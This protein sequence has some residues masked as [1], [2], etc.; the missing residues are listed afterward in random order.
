[1]F[2]PED[3]TLVLLFWYGLSVGYSILIGSQ[4]WC[5]SF[6][7]CRIAVTHSQPKWAFIVSHSDI[8]KVQFTES[9]V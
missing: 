8:D 9:N 6:Q 1:M 4:F 7:L 2:T 5:D 3:C